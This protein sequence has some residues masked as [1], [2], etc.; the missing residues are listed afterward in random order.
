MEMNKKLFRKTYRF[1]CSDCGEFSHTLNEYCEMCGS[2]GTL[3]N[4]SRKEFK[5][6]A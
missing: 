6:R 2:F 4:A 1:V 3:H 5:N